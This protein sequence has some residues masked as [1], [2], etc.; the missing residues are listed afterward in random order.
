MVQQSIPIASTRS[1]IDI[2]LKL[3]DSWHCTPLLGT[4]E[5]AIAA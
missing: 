5:S 1:S 2:K 4:V 3:C